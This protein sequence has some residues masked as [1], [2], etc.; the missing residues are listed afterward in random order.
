M[1]GMSLHWKIIIGMIFGFIFGLLA[2]NFGLVL[3]TQNWIKPFGVI[4]VNLLKLIA[5]PLVFAS[6]VKGIS[7][8][9]NTS[10][11]S[12]IGFKTIIFYILSTVIA[13]TIGLILVNVIQP[14]DAFSE[15]AKNDLKKSYSTEIVEKINSAEDVK[16]G[17]PL[18]FLVDIVPSNIIYSATEN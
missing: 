3:F 2:N 18:Q 1:K 10:K 6:L 15:I 9:S 16:G 13:V 17:S 14:G 11:I 12:V 8:L 7:S 5:V 4:F